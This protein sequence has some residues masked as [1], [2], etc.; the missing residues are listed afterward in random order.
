MTELEPE[1][2]RIPTLGRCRIESPLQRMLSGT[3]GPRF[4][5]E[6]E[7]VLVQ[8]RTVAGGE[9]SEEICNGAGFERAGPRA[10]IYFEPAKVRC[11][12]VTCGGLCP[13]VNDVIRGLVSA[14]WNRYG[15]RHIVGFRY[16]LQGFIPEYGHSVIELTPA[17]VHGIHQT[18]GTLLGTSRG[19]QDIEQVVDCLERM[20]LGV[21]FVVGGGGTM[22]AAVAMSELLAARELKTVVVGIP[23]AIDNDL[24]FIDQSFGFETA[25]SEAVK[26]IRTA[27]VEAAGAPHGVGLVRLMGRHSG[28]IAC[29][30]T[31]A[32]GAVNFTLIPEVPFQ[33][34][35]E[36]GLLA[37]LEQRLDHHGHAVIVAAEGAGLH[38]PSRSECPPSL[39]GAISV[40][41][42]DVGD[43]LKAEIGSYFARRKGIE[44][45]LKYVDPSYDIRSVPA[46]ASDSIYCLRLAQSAVHA[47]MCGKTA[48]V[49]GRWHGSLVHVPMTVA[50]AGRRQV[51]P[52]GDLWLSVLE[53]TGQPASWQ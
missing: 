20:N 38:L 6:A 49:V 24:M 14:L 33:I 30:A 28:F 36:G 39:S 25:Y 51:D 4:I 46:S 18:G 2:T 7:R 15:V 19:R 3:H 45:N 35:G 53:D 34:H 22:R 29:H 27:H 42:E 26:S 13:G 16:G 31:L 5:D 10:H 44:L 1:R 40:P 17:D 21:L 32:S 52:R 41:R 11:G 48:M 9:H 8:D 12:I 23:K 50:A 43:L 47:A 37:Q